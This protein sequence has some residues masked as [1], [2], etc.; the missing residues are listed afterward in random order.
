MRRSPPL[1]GGH[2]ARVC[3]FCASPPE[4]WGTVALWYPD[5]ELRWDPEKLEFTN[6]PEA[7][8]LLH[9]EPRKGWEL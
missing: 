3:P 9:F 7:T 6:N 8:R 5:Q 1:R 2:S 4:R